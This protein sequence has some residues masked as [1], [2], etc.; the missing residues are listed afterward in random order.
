MDDGQSSQ[1]C[2]PREHE[3]RHIASRP[4][5]KEACERRNEHPADGSAK[6]SD[7]HHRG[8]GVTREHVGSQG[9][10]ICG[11]TLM[12]GGGKADQCNCN[13]KAVHIRC[14]DDRYN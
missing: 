3:Y 12:R 6:T 9:I 11:P 4:L 14:Y 2:G 5:E 8:Y 7:S 13:P 10:E 1:I